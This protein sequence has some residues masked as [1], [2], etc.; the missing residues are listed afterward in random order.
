LLDLCFGDFTRLRYYG[1]AFFYMAAS[2]FK[3]GTSRI[4]HRADMAALTEKTAAS[5]TLG[6]LSKST[7]SN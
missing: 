4:N 6:L 2:H 5:R 3:D 1:G 7:P